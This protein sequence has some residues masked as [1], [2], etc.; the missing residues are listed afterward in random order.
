MALLDETY[1]LESDV[2]YQS[3][4]HPTDDRMAHRWRRRP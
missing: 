1:P 4:E 2:A 3:V